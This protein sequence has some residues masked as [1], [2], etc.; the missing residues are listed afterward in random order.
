MLLW[1]VDPQEHPRTRR[2]GFKSETR[3]RV[4]F[5]IGL[6]MFD[7]SLMTFGLLHV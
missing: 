3:L 6:K 7:D 4:I 5:Q 1:A 2:A